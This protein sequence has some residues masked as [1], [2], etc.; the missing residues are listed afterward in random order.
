MILCSADVA[1][2]VLT[3]VLLSPKTGPSAG[4]VR[5]RYN[6]TWGSVCGHRILPSTVTVLCHQLGYHSYHNYSTNSAGD[7]DNWTVGVVCDGS[8]SSLGEC[9]TERSWT[10]NGCAQNNILSV[11]CQGILILYNYI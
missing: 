3:Q 2:P 9:F 6:G 8:E 5:V 1:H 10:L 7:G 11:T 4:T